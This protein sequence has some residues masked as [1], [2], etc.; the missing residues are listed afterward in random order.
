MRFFPLLGLVLCAFLA[1]SCTRHAPAHPDYPLQPVPVKDVVITDRFWAPKIAVNRTVSLQHCLRMMDETGSFDTPKLI[2][3]AAYMLALRRD[4]SLEPLIDQRI[5]RLVSRVESRITRPEQ[6]VRVSGHYLEAAAAYYEATGKRRMLDSA[7]KLAG[8]IDAAYGP[9]KKTYISGHEGLKIGLLRLYRVTGDERYSKLARFFLDERGRDDYPRE[10]EYARDR[11]YAQDHRPVVQQAEAVGHAVRAM[12]LYIPLTD[13]AAVTGRRDYLEADDRIWQDA[14]GRKTYVTG[15]IGSIRFHEQFGT[16]YQLP[17]LSAWNETCASYGS[18]V[19]NHRL[20][21]LHRDAKY[22]DVMERVLYNAFLAGVSLAGDRFFYQNPLMSY[23]NYERFSWINVPCCPPNVVRLLASL[24]GY[25][26]A[27]RENDLYVNLFV[28][29]SARV[30]L[31]GSAV[32]IAQQTRYPWDGRVTIAIAPDRPTRFAVH[33]RVPGWARNQV[34]PGELYRYLDADGETPTVKVDGVAFPI[35]MDKG[36]ARIDRTWRKGD[37]IE[38][39]LPMAVRRVVADPQVRDDQG[40]VALMR[41]PLVYCL[42]W[43]DNGG[44]A[45]NALIDDHAPLASRFRAD[46]L[47]GVQVITA[48]ASTVER[49]ADAAGVRAEPRSLVAIPY[50]AWANRGMGEMAVWIA[51]R[52]EQARLQPAPPAPIDEV[53]AFGGIRKAWTGYNDQNDDLGAVYDG[54]DP[55]SSADESNLYFRMRPPAGQ[56]AWIEYRFKAPATV[57]STEVYWVDD[58]RFCRLPAS[59]RILYRSG[60]RWKPVNARGTYG[61]GRDAFNR[62]AF[63]P[64]E[65]TAV[66]LEIEPQKVHY[67]AGQ[68]GPPDAMFLDRDVDWREAGVIEWRISASR[69][70]SSP[71]R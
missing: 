63:D 11:T 31:G 30:T 7:L 6:A 26:Y 29:S 3:A 34:L 68:I 27:R 23:G 49:T 9:G 1:G 62:V 21:L 4:P 19:W 12:F 67:A 32:S 28:G 2:E 36:Y 38:L 50:F 33:L 58:S 25:V 43:P 42:E 8:M 35:A 54:A 66:R 59:W 13:A 69:S 22:V 70:E 39:Q 52:A 17:N 24:G 57:A 14:V 18:V 15:G 40:R 61:V 51:R 71:R 45:L 37:E 16:P 10:G 60:A 5:D 56:P 47:N 55:L 46:L 53:K 48:N 44:H 41:G 64:V 20:F 65:T